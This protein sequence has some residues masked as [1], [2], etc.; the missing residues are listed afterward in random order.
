MPMQDF[1]H[2][3]NVENYRRLLSEELGDAERV[4]ILKLLAEEQARDRSCEILSLE[5]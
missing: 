3:Q 5:R 4:L 1:N 2:R